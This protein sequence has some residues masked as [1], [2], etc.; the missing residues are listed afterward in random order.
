MELLGFPNRGKP[1]LVAVSGGVDSM[2]LAC[3][4]H[5]S[6]HHMAVAHCNYGLR[7][8]DSDADE[9]LVR[10]WCDERGIEFHV[11][12]V[13]IKHLMEETNAS[14]QMV[15]R[16]ERYAFF[17]ELMEMH[18]Y[19][20]TALAHHANDRVES[21]IINLLRGTGYRG[22]LGMPSQRDGFIRPMLGFTKNEIRA[23]AENHNV[24]FRE[25]RSN[26]ETYYQ[27]NWVRLK[28]LPM[29]LA[30]DPKAFEKLLQFAE[31]AEAQLPEYKHFVTGQLQKLVSG[32]E[33]SVAAME[34]SNFPFTMLKEELEP[35]GFNSEQVFEVLQLLDSDS[36]SVVSSNTHRV[37]KERDRLIISELKTNDT[38]PLIVCE[39]MERSSLETLV[40]ESNVALIDAGAV[41]IAL[42]NGPLTYANSGFELRKWRN[43]DCFKPLG[44]NGWKL[45]SDFFIDQKYSVLEKQQTWLLTFQ[46]EVVWVVGKRLDNRFRVTSNTKKVLKLTAFI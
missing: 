42:T 20:A 11:K 15:A 39:T 18:G 22:F 36:G 17:N 23:F 44:M 8:D 43:G 16:V 37:L 35:L 28:L 7:G 13:D 27:R 41:T 9:Q 4:L 25:D 45:L 6:G 32:S 14:I 5:R 19:R 12:A 46:G 26:A 2:V 29:L 24:P 31:R 33:I 40:T 3:L 38:A 10:Q 30:T 34:D 21:L 1:L